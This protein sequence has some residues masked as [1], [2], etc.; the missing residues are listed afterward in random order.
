MQEQYVIDLQTKYEEKFRFTVVRQFEDF[1][2]EQFNQW[3]R[4]EED[5]NSKYKTSR[6][7]L[8]KP[9]ME[10]VR[11]LNELTH[12]Q[13]SGNKETLRK[14]VKLQQV[15]D[16]IIK[17]VNNGNI[18]FYDSIEGKQVRLH[19]D[20]NPAFFERLCWIMSKFS[21]LDQ[22]NAIDY[23]NIV[24]RKIY[25]IV[26]ECKV[27][28]MI[29]SNVGQI[30][31]MVSGE[32]KRL[33]EILGFNIEKFTSMTH[34]AEA[35][36]NQLTSTMAAT[37]DYTQRSSDELQK[38]KSAYEEKIAIAQPINYWKSR[39]YIY[40]RRVWLWGIVA[41]LV[42]ILFLFGVWTALSEMPDLS[43]IEDIK[44]Q[45]KVTVLF[46]TGIGIMT[47]ILNILGRLFLSSVHLLSDIDERMNLTHFYLSLI[48]GGKLDEKQREIIL[49]SLFSRTDSGIIK[50]GGDVSFPMNFESIKSLFHK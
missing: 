5:Y 31:S 42:G 15:V 32:Y 17:I 38:L 27:Q 3:Q 20:S 40:Q 26:L 24:D 29:I 46:V 23:G 25:Q 50:G 7:S 43:K 47:F 13:K 41:F 48:E 14:D 37:T 45:I 28:A 39:R 35:I 30:E 6:E 21:E 4:I 2:Q 33:A 1:A 19:Q 18:L 8:R 22:F 49:Q 16:R 12:E 34:G 44:N 10:I 11:I 9:W 36:I